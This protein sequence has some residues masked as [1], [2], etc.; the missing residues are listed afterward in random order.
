MDWQTIVV[1]AT[2]GALALG[3]GYWLYRDVVRH[4]GNPMIWVTLYAIAI[5]P[6]T[7]LRFILGPAVFFAWFMVRGRSFP[8]LSRA[9]RAAMYLAGKR[10]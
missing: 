7:R 8:M 3:P 6:P 5:V 4:G 9:K 2:I 1:I 10:N